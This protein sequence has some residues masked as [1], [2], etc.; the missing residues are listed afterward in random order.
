MVMLIVCMVIGIARDVPTLLTQG[1]VP[2]RDD[3]PVI[4]KKL[5]CFLMLLGAA[6]ATAAFKEAWYK[7][8]K[9]E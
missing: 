2:L 1:Y 5:L 9:P 4:L 6:G 8:R 3:F 7:S